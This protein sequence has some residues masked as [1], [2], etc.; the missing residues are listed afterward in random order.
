VCLWPIIGVLPV[1]LLIPVAM[2]RKA[3]YLM[4]NHR[5]GSTPFQGAPSVGAY[6]AACLQGFG[7]LM[8][9]GVIIFGLTM[10][11]VMPAFVGVNMKDPAQMKV[12]MGHAQ[13]MG[14]MVNWVATVFMVFFVLPFV[15]AKMRNAVFAG[16]TLG[17]HRFKSR[18]SGLG[19]GGMVFVNFIVSVVT[20]G[21][22]YP[23]AQIRQARYI[24]ERTTLYAATDLSEF[25]ADAEPPGSVTAS[26][27][28]MLE[29]LAVGIGT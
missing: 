2:H 25:R 17:P 9:I 7:F 20:L 24:A 3:A 23:W 11:L 4:R 5:F 15:R 14:M 10:A 13:T 12:A 1:G 16:L 21:L 26:E 19:Y 18:M 27:L 29:G 6:Y 8:L 28:A 22:M